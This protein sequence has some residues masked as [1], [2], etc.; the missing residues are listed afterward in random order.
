MRDA[1]CCVLAERVRVMGSVTSTARTMVA[2][3]PPRTCV[4]ESQSTKTT[5]AIPSRTNSASGVPTCSTRLRRRGSS[6]FATSTIDSPVA[7]SA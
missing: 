7:S 1:A 2:A 5:H 6:M 3:P 4:R